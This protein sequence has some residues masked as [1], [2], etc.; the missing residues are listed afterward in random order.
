MSRARPAPLLVFACLTLPAACSSS[1]GEHGSPSTPDAATDL[2]SDV[3]SDAPEDTST[4]DAPADAAPP[5]FSEKLSAMDLYDDIAAKTI[6]KA[7]VPYAPSYELWSDAADKARW[8]R[9]PAGAKIDSTDMDHWQFPVGTRLWK[10]FAKGGKRLE[11]RLL[12][13]TGK[14]DWR[15]GA[16]VW[17]DAQT[18]ATWTPDGAANVLGTEHDVPKNTDCQ[19]CHEGEPGRVIGFSAIQLAKATGPTTLASI[20]SWLTAPPEAG[21]EYGAPGDATAQAAL[22]YLH[23]NCGHCHNANDALTFL[24]VNQVLRLYVGERVVSETKLYMSSVNVATEKYKTR[25]YRIE[26]GS[27]STSA[28]WDRMNRRDKDQMPPIASEQTHA[29]GLAAVKAWIDGL[30]KP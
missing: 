6:A 5:P 2:G 20:A 7:N 15:M 8:I 9:L 21:K 28:T 26:G 22:G 1:E 16:Y 23:A 29:A 30:P 13:K 14:D 18:E 12:E 3:A 10:E 4:E 17:N 24:A 27:A 25:P 19:R 11:T